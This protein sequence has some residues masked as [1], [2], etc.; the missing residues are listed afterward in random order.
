MRYL[1]VLI[2]IVACIGSA[3]AFELGSQQRIEKENTHVGQ[4]PGTPDNRQGGEDMATAIQILSMPFSDTGNTTGHV[5]DYDEVCPY[6]GS[7]AAD[8][9]YYYQPDSD[10]VLSVDLCGSGYDTK[11][12][13]Y[14]GSGNLV[15][16]NDDAY[17]DDTCGIY[18][19]LIEA[20][21]LNAG[22]TYYFVIDGYGEDTGDYI[23]NIHEFFPE[24]PC[25]LECDGLQEGEPALG[26]GYEDAFNG[27]CNSP[28]YGAPW[29]DLTYASDGNG[30]LLYCGIAGWTDSGRDTDWNYLMM[31]EQGLVE[32]TVDAEQLTSVYTLTMS[33]CDDVVVDQSMAVGICN[34]GTLVIQGNPGD[35]F[36]LW[37]GS[38][39]FT[40]PAGFV[41]YEY[42]YVADFTGLYAGGCIPTENSS[43]GR[44]KS[45]Y[46]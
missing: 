1:T 44:I 16:C 34:P 32:V 39:E 37:F 46:R 13:I 26:P 21:F 35:V 10:V 3:Y 11:T 20:A 41:G 8:L 7:T 40:P 17:F 38:S 28:E 42:N 9:V 31:G 45:L 5:D 33:N 27:G 24:P 2:L 22:E 25:I 29:G 19:S 14:E 15:F 6:S 4:N 43:I 18:V 30:E 23:L 36:M 12:Y